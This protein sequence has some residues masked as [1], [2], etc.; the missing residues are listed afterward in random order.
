MADSGIID[1]A[2]D[3]DTRRSLH[4]ERRWATR[5]FIPV[6]ITL[7]AGLVCYGLFFNRQVWPIV[8]GYNISPAERVMQ[9]EAPYRD[10][11]YNYTPGV[12]WLNALLMELFG[13]SLMTVAIGMFVFRLAALFAL[14]F[15]AQ[16]FCN[17]WRALIPVALT[18]AWLGQKYVFG[19][20]PAQ[21]FMFFALLGAAFLLKHDDSNRFYWLFLSG[22]MV[23]I[24]FVFKYNVGIFLLASGMAA[25][26]IKQLMKAD[27]LPVNTRQVF[28]V[29]KKALVY[30]SG[31]GLIVGAMFI[32][33]AHQ[34][35]LGP[36][37]DHFLHHAAE[38]SAKRRGFL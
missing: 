20:V 26:L 5:N 23:G 9:G 15:I 28:A 16:H 36:M 6:I 4:R 19:A 29:M 11:L 10:F 13:A 38:Y 3:D 32:Y 1:V 27:G 33:L 2:I 37:I 25:I 34:R 14:F 30:F 35:A 24:V 21:Y 8:V 17:R 31:F 18:L 7:V 22:L 12:L